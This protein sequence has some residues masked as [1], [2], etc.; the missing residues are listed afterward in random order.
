[1]NLN[2]G[3]EINLVFRQN[4]DGV[5]HSEK[6]AARVTDIRGTEVFFTGRGDTALPPSVSG[7]FPLQRVNAGTA[8]DGVVSYE[9]VGQTPLMINNG[10]DVV[11]ARDDTVAL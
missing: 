2:I 3:T 4:V 7:S 9:I 8:T 6:L 5:V 11:E 10:G 1:M